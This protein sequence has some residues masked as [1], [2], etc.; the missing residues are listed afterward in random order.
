MA[1]PAWPALRAALQSSRGWR[2]RGQKESDSPDDAPVAVH[3]FPPDGRACAS[4]AIRFPRSEGRRVQ[5]ER[6]TALLQALTRCGGAT[7]GP[8]PLAEK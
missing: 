1:E 7:A 8:L 6:M 2:Y 5:P 3:F 4:V